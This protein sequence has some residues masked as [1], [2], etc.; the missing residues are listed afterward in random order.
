MHW[1]TKKFIL[2]LFIEMFALLRR[3]GTQPTASLRH[4]Y[5]DA[6]GV[7]PIPLKMITALTEY[8]TS[9]SVFSSVI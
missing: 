1:E 6:N 8:Y 3:S 4:A 2:T 7:V 5:N 9:A